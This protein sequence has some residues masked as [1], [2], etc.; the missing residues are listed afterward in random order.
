MKSNINEQDQ[1]TEKWNQRYTIEFKLS[2]KH[3]NQ[4]IFIAYCSHFHFSIE[5]RFSFVT[6]CY[7]LISAMKL[8]KYE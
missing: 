7:P 4:I 5:Y 3:W 6:T 8:I 1:S 2:I